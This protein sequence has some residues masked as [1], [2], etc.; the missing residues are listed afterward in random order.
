VCLRA[1]QK[2]VERVCRVFFDAIF[3]TLDKVHFSLL[4]AVRLCR[5]LASQF[6]YGLRWICKVMQSF[7]EKQLPDTSKALPPASSLMSLQ[8]RAYAPRRTTCF[9]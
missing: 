1:L 2:D 5:L 9:D 3:S 8:R 4:P 7:C 6:P